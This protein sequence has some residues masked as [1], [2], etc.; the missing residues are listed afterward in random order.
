M[1]DKDICIDGGYL[2][3]IWELWCA[4]RAVTYQ[5]EYIVFTE[6]HCLLLQYM[7]SIILF[8]HLD[9]YYAK[10]FFFFLRKMWLYKNQ[11]T[12]KTN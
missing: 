4:T 7:K 5:K 3:D 6:A 2:K 12:V 8:F 9:K 1:L 10:R 11:P